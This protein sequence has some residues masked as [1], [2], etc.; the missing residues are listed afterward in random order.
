MGRE[1]KEGIYACVQL[2]RFAVRWK[3]TH[4]KATI[5][6]KKFFCLSKTSQKRFRKRT[7][8]LIVT[9]TELVDEKGREEGGVVAQKYICE[10]FYFPF[11]IWDQ[12]NSQLHYS[13]EL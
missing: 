1:S 9:Y 7:C 4:Y 8:L 10:I 2:I 3:L 6:K 13:R 11:I 12:L 5:L